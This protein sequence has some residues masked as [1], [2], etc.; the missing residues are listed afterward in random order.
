ML[1]TS[2]PHLLL[3]DALRGIAALVVLY[4]H[5]FECFG[6]EIAEGTGLYTQPCDHG[7]LAVDFFFLLSGF[8]IAYAYDERWNGRD[9][10][11]GR[12]GLSVLTFFK[13]RLIR[14]HPMVIAGAFIGLTC[15]FIDG[16]TDWF[17]NAATPGNLALAFFMT[18]VMFP[19]FPGWR[20][21]V[22]GNGEMFPLNGPQWSLFFEYIGNIIYALL[23]RKFST[24]ALAMVTLVCGVILGWH[25]L[26]TAS[27]GDGWSFV[28]GGFWWGLLR[29]LF[30]Y[31]LGMLLCRI[32]MKR[33]K[34]ASVDPKYVVPTFAAC[35]SMLIVLLAM[36]FFGNPLHTWQNGYYI[37]LLTY[38]V[39]PVIIWAAASAGHA[40]E[41]SHTRFTIN[42]LTFLGELS[43]PLY[44][45]HY[46]LMYL[47]YRYHGF[48]NVTCT[49]ADVWPMAVV[50]FCGSLLLAT[51]LL[52]AYDRPI[53]NWMNKVY[54]NS[55]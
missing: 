6:Y 17:G 38:V 50:T 33:N 1:S 51:F 11:E 31:S 16:S 24:N 40:D 42:S 29:M 45:V 32:F 43:Y 35:S 23:L 25:I 26:E 10:T 55:N 14:L 28:S 7:Y 37:L 44:I 3:L 39:F 4:Y 12:K 47:F 27:L 48:P 54:A 20:V 36:P 22:R 15:F 18:L 9:K 8:V 2:K 41:H 46:P 13:R 21:D 53:R 49:M 34:D 30:P 5:C 52:Y 19:V